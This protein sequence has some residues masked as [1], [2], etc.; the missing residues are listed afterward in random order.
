M[1]LLACATPCEAQ[2]AVRGDQILGAW[3]CVTPGDDTEVTN[4]VV[5][6][7]GGKQTFDLWM[8]SKSPFLKLEINATG[9]VDW[10]L[11]ADGKLE[12]TIT[13]FT[14]VGSKVDGRPTAPG[15]LE[16]ITGE[17]P[18]KMGQEVVNKKSDPSAVQFNDGR[19]IISDER[20]TTTC[21]R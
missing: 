15:F 17:D 13:K 3:T 14:V 18:A 1:A 6:L 5:F 4:S 10:N 20:A 2:V 9:T 12:Q 21:T 8:K 16:T 19:L 7:R 11:L